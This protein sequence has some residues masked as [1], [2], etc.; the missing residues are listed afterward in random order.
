MTM[1]TKKKSHLM[2]IDD[3]KHGGDY[4]DDDCETK[5][6]YSIQAKTTTM[7]TRTM[8]RTKKKMKASMNWRLRP[9]YCYRCCCNSR[10]N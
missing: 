3:M 1:R 7:M 8:K 4:D 2:T 6:M 5:P 10:S 9:L